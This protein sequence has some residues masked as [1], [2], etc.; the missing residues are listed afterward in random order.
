V[1]RRALIVCYYFPPLGLAGVGRPLNLFKQLPAHGWNCDVLTVKPVAYRA[2]EPELLEGLDLTRIYRAGSYD[3]QRLMYL[4]GYRNVSS[5]SLQ[6]GYKIRS[7]FFPDS[8]KGWVGPAVRLGKRLAARNKYDLIFSTAP[9]MSAHL[10]ALK[11]H[12]L[13][14]I[15]WIADYRDYWTSD[16]I[17]QQYSSPRTAA[18]AH[19]LLRSIAATARAVTAV[20]KSVGDYVGAGKLVSN[21]FDA[22]NAKLWGTPNRQGQFSIGML[23]TFGPLNPIEPLFGVIDQLRQQ[24]PAFADQ[25]QVVQVGNVD[26]DNFLSLAERHG[27]K[28]RCQAHGLKP[29]AESIDLL[30]N[31]HCFYQSL[32][33]DWGKGMTPARMFDLLASGR[34]ILAYADHGGEVDKMIVTSGNGFC[35]GDPQAKEAAA[36]LGGLIEANAKGTLEIRPI[37][38]Y[39]EPYRWERIAGEFATLFN[40]VL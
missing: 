40:S 11:L 6:H 22:T 8:K 5:D 37:P 19:E 7:R 20:N 23:G 3:P 35:F 4:I 25:V 18:H 28:D 31:C 34:P 24:A 10:A 16:T 14:G 15:P 2:Y 38:A 30:K 17:E 26:R 1:T 27:L 33:P 9:P 29:R 39:A 13:S 21:G 32:L 12:Q 36:Y